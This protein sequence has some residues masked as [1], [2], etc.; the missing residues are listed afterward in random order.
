MLFSRL[1]SIFGIICIIL[2][3]VLFYQRNNPKRIKFSQPPQAVKI[4][5]SKN[6][7]PTR[8]AIKKVNIDLIIFP[9]KIID[10]QW[11]IST[12]GASWLDISPIPG[13][14][15]NSIL[16]GHNWTNL[17]G[18]LIFVR[19][20]QEIEIT[21][22]NGSKKIFIVDKTAIVSPTNVSVLRQTS[23]K[24]ITV[25][26]CTGLFDEKRFIVAAQ[27]KDSLQQRL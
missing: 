17:M 23:D 19:P 1:L 27:L 9:A 15:G 7:S 20:G 18:N 12:Q 24:R 2:A 13:E 6:I 4:S 3:A 11:D 25:Y 5:N 8:I 22:K 16:Y 21:Y 26:T 14:R 10:Q